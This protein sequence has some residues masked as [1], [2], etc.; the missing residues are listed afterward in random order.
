MRRVSIALVAASA[1]AVVAAQQRPNFS[2][3]WVRVNPEEGAGIEQIVRHEGDVLTTGHG[4]SGGG[5]HG[6]TYRLDGSE[7]RNVITSHG[8]EI[9][10]IST[11]TWSGPELTIVSA[12]TYPDGR[13]LRQTQV[14]SI[15]T[16]GRLIV[17]LTERADGQEPVTLRIVLRKHDGG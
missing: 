17:Q 9:V 8:S 3:R 14:W 11:A 12:T 6:A 1:V 15:D 16:E 7:N 10:T 5:H 13:R 4:A 2:G